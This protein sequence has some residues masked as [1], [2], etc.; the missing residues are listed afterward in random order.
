MPAMN[1]IQFNPCWEPLPDWSPP[2]LRIVR[3]MEK[4]SMPV[5]IAEDDPVSRKLVTTVIEMGGYRTIVTNDGDEAMSALRAQK[6]P[7]V[8]VVDWM[9]PGIDGAEI[10]RRSRESDRSVYIIMVT[11]RGTKKDTVEGIDQGADDYLVKP[12][13]PEELL[14]RIR[15]GLRV[16]KTQEMLARRVEALETT[17][18]ETGLLTL[19][20]PL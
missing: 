9:M 6:K 8:A 17:A 10:C 18:S 4:E 2:A 12:F 13:D 5:V 19:R 7:C 3:P 14:A 16:M 15:V 11:A 20:I 1:C